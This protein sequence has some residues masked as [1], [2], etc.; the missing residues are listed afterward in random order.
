MPYANNQDIRIHYK[1]EGEGPP[2]V[3]QHGFTSSIEDWYDFGYVT[4]LKKD[5]QLILIDARGHGASDKPHDPAAYD[6][7]L[8]VRDVTAV[9]DELNLS[10]A[11]FLGYSM[12]GRI[13]F[14]IAKY[15]PERFP[16]L[17][18]G[19]MH[20]YKR[21][22]RPFEQRIKL[23]REGTEAMLVGLEKRN[24]Q[25]PPQARARKLS[26]DPEALIAATMGNLGESGFDEVLSTITMPCLLY[27]GES[28]GYYAGAVE[29]VKHMP[30]VTFVSLPGLNHAQ[31]MA[32][33]DLV[34]PHVT[35]FL[36]SIS[37]SVQPTG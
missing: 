18:I 31:T 12:G 15:A 26:N 11:Y 23:L 36:K 32:S 19:G 34:L 24:G 13:G 22:S 7:K 35:K 1:V 20:P 27:V 25:L 30:N 6:M 33:G 5:H 9:L 29:C 37:K 3:L 28:D 17:I 8:R 10:K 14:G 21:E 16:S 2:L 4:A